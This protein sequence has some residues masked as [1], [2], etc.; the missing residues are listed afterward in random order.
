MGGSTRYS[1][2][3]RERA[4]GMVLEHRD[5]YESQWAS[6]TSIA[7]KT[8]YASGLFSACL[9]GL[10]SSI[11]PANALAATLV[12]PSRTWGCFRNQVLVAAA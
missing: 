8:G 2:E 4:V 5:E 10:P 7:S 9:P 12:S 3:V 6:L 11:P 1:S